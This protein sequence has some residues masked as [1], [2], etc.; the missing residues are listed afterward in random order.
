MEVGLGDARGLCERSEPCS[1]GALFSFSADAG[2]PARPVVA[3]LGGTSCDGLML[4]LRTPPV[5]GAFTRAGGIGRSALDFES[6]GCTSKMGKYLYSLFSRISSH[7]EFYHLGVLLE[8]QHP[9]VWA[10]SFWDWYFPL[11]LAIQV[12]Y[13]E[14]LQL[15]DRPILKPTLLLDLQ[16]QVQ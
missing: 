13:W 4:V 15:Q 11:I 7:K 12:V 2:L 6:K 8:D 3:E 9:E 14:N 5:I 10:S 1:E 16:P